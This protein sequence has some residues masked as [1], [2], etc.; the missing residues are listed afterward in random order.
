MKP[1]APTPLAPTVSQAR[2]LLMLRSRFF[3]AVAMGLEW[4]DAPEVETM[5]TDGTRLWYNERWCA[6]IGIE[7]TIG[8]IVHECCH[9]VNKHHLRMGR[10]PLKRWN[11]AA[12]LAINPALLRDGWALPED[13][14]L[15][16]ARLYHK[17]TAERIDDALKQEEEEKAG[18]DPGQDG[19]NSGN[20]GQ[21]TGQKPDGKGRE[22]DPGEGN[23]CPAPGAAGR[24]KPVDG[25][26]A[27]AR[28]W[29]EV[30]PAT[31]G[32]G[33]LLTPAASRLAEDKLNQQVRQAMR[34]ASRAGQST[35]WIEEIIEASANASDWTGRLASSLAGVGRTT[36]SWSRPNRRY[37]QHGLYMPG[38]RET[39]AGRVAFV[40]D[41]SGS[42]TPDDLS[43]YC[44]AV[45]GVVEDT[46]PEQV[47]VIQ[48]DTSVRHV[49]WLEQGECLDG[50]TVHGGG[51][52]LFQPAFDWIEQN[53]E[54]DVIIYATDLFS[55]DKPR[56]PHVA[57]I[58]LTPTLGRTPSFGEV[59]GIS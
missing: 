39:G 31:D 3:G 52:T 17:W 8:L 11:K 48:C 44:G 28:S 12:D 55:A 56:D 57:T 19:E 45:V 26:T 58:W 41:T 43:A 36:R 14:Y 5:A 24:E 37:M 49:Q 53:M 7:K 21:A 25:P 33:R 1:R 6:E 9:K 50:V 34:M 46:G 23:P 18:N 40:M 4:I 2:K 35:A 16:R 10:R 30:R 22:D 54:A 59:L 38:K 51:G 32:N 29:G 27:P 20:G 13:L 42:I 47:A 15:D